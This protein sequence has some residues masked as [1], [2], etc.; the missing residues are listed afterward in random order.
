MVGRRPPAFAWGDR[1]LTL[2]TVGK[3]SGGKH[4]E[5]LSVAKV[6]SFFKCLFVFEILYPLPIAATKFS[7]LFYYRRIFKVQE[8]KLPFYIIAALIG[9]WLFYSVRLSQRSEQQWCTIS[10]GALRRL[11]PSSRVCLSTPCGIL[12]LKVDASIFINTLSV[13][14]C[15]TL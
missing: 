15:R 3:H 12:S 10:P 9:C 4:A 6:L 11:W 13:T 7:I 14:P 1:Q 8:F 5:A 2:L